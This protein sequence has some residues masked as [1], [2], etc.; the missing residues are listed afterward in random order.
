M[1]KKVFCAV[2]VIFFAK[3]ALFAQDGAPRQSGD[4]WV[5]SV[6]QG[7]TL[8]EKIGQ[9]FMIPVYS[10]GNEQHFRVVQNYIERYGVGGLIFMQGSPAKQLALTNRFQGQSGVP[11]LMGMDLEWGMGM[12]LD[13]TRSFPKQITLG[14]I[15]NDTLIYEMGMEIARQMK[16][17]GVHV[18]FAPVVDIN[19]NPRNPV[20]GFRSFGED[21]KQ[22]TRKGI[23]YM[24]GL[25]DG[26]VLACAKHFPGHGDTDMDS[27][28]T[29]PTIHTDRLQLDTSALYPFEKLITAG[30]AC[31]LVAHLNI[32]SLED[33]EKPL[34][35]SLSPSVI[36][37]LLRKDMG[38][39]GL[40]FSDA[41]NMKS[42]SGRYAAGETERLAFMAGNDMLLF[43]Q[44]LPLAFKLIRKTVKGNKDHKAA[45][46]SSV[47]R[48]L[49]A[50]Y[51]V[52]L[53][54]PQKLHTDNLYH[55]LFRKQSD[56][57][58]QQLYEAAQTVV[59][60]E[61][62][63]IPVTALDGKTFASLTI[64]DHAEEFKKMLDK[65]AFFTHYQKRK[66]SN[67]SFLLQR[68]KQYDR[69]VVGVLG[70]SND[71]KQHYN[72]SKRDIAFL[73][74]LQQITGVIV[75]VFGNPYSL[76][77]FEGIKNL[78]CAYQQNQDTERI[79]P[80]IIFGGLP[81]TGKLP[82]SVSQ[83]LPAGS[84]LETTVGSR[85]SY[86]IPE[87]S[88]MD[89]RTLQRLD[90]IAREAIATG[91]TPGCQVLVARDGKIVFEKGYGYYTYDS[92]QPVTDQ[93]VYDVA[94][95]TKV[96]AT[97]QAI[98]FL[99][100]RGEI[101]LD[102]KVS[103]YLPELK[104]TN[105][106]HMTLRDILTHQAGLWP[107]LPFWKNTLDDT[108]HS[109]LFYSYQPQGDF[110]FQV[111]TGLYATNSIRDS[112][113]HWVV[114]SKMRKKE[115][116]KPYNYK[117]S[118]MGFYILH[119]LAEALLNQPMEV[120]LQQNFYEPLGATTLGYV[121]LCKY[122][123]DRIA[124]TEDD[125]YFRNSMVYGHVHDQGAAMTGGIAGHAGLFSNANDL[126]KLM[127]MHLQDGTYGD[128][129]F[130]EA[131][132]IEEFTRQQYHSNRRGA[133]WDK[134]LRGKWYGPTSEF[135]SSATYGHT[136]FTGTAVWSDPEFNL[137]F[138]FLSNRIHPDATN[139]KL[140]KS[141]I[142]TRMQDVVYKSIFNYEQ[143]GD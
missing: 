47:R 26:G 30:V 39:E 108:I 28:Y 98:M 32:P 138:V 46:D 35:S 136:G 6:F 70:L 68:L 75:V 112:I 102:K 125:R 95:I 128:A 110:R 57:L 17:L 137:I 96:A 78:V 124:P 12:R 43:P 92:I 133:G 113:W 114:D 126:A 139:T 97:L 24:K 117:Y 31:A 45:L 103:Y 104:G 64:G 76:R 135:C 3:S 14:A 48:I 77:G 16:T 13:S 2:F 15:D 109:P 29:L 19:S 1:I 21:K 80:Q 87:A 55:K 82:V 90:V 72:V 134:P 81:A 54:R 129:R 115:R 42:V 38:F 89:S 85:L 123:L 66:D 105:K 61:E 101:D 143:F 122:S 120:F 88:G 130:Y 58:I 93:T 91:A 100:E 41:L 116:R 11:L 132:T 99:K 106:E 20:I 60:N 111:A 44:N 83:N 73:E 8:E 33:P 127:Q 36:K 118:D 119:R 23:A 62:E 141:N 53:H 69:V 63:A 94:S 52:G 4:R 56:R 65:Y 74:Q 84:G 79:T 18:N 10:N 140:I 7:L 40:V 67:E 59:K 34:P 49:T 22:V 27:H 25:Q 142:R 5:D 50:K 51:K 131:G 37:K 107:Y 121:P 71:P 86:S 9:L